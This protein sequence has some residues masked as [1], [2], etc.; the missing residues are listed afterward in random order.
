VRAACAKDIQEIVRV[1]NQAYIVEQFCLE[2]DRTDADEVHSR[3]HLGQFLVIED[4]TSAAGLRG[5]VFMSVQD[6]RGYLGTLSVDPLHQG[7]GLARALVEAVEDRCRLAGCR[8]L[9]LTVVNLRKEL[10]PFYGRLGFSPS[11]VL[12]FPRP[13][14]VIQPLHLVQMTK[15]LC[16]AEDL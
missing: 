11:A 2:G 16:A 3:M 9:D 13:E 8:F 14:K 10:F 15:A 6:G 12:P 7:K 1:I 5:A 4:L